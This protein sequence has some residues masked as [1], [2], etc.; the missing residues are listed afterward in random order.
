MRTIC[1]IR[2]YEARRYGKD[3]KGT[4]LQP[5]KRA[6]CD[7]GQTME[8]KHSKSNAPKGREIANKEQSLFDVRGMIAELKRL[9]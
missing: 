4:G 2:Q 1:L 5:I 3:S 9:K 6:R 7:A 8:R